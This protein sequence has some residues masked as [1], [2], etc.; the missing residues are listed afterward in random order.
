VMLTEAEN[1]ARTLRLAAQSGTGESAH[2]A[3]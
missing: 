3:A 2:R 1:H